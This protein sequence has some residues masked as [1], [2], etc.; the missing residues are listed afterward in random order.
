[1]GRVV[2]I[3]PEGNP[4]EFSAEE[5]PQRIREGY[6][7]ESKQ[8]RAERVGKEARLST[9]SGVESFGQAFGRGMTAGGTDVLQRAA[10]GEAAAQ[11]L[12]EAQEAHPTLD[13]V[14]ELSGVVLPAV[15]S[16]GTSV[17]ARTPAAA[18]TRFG[19]NIARAGEGASFVTKVGRAAAGAATEGALFGAGTGASEVALS[20]KPVDL[21]RAISTISSNM[22]YG[23]LVGGAAGSLGKVA[24]IG[25]TKAKGAIDGAL[26]RHEASAVTDDLARMD[27]KQLD[28]VIK[29]EKEAIETARVAERK[30]VAED[31]QALR[32][33]IKDSKHFLTTEEVKL[34]AV[35]GKLTAAEIGKKAVKA[36]GLLRNL[37]D[38]PRG[39]AAKPEMAAKALRIQED[40]YTALLDR[41]DDFR[42]AFAADK[43]GA[44]MAALDSIPAALEKNRAIQAQLT[45]LGAARSTERLAAAESA[46]EALK[47]GG[48]AL[49]Q[50]ASV[51]QRMV[52]GSVF[53]MAAGA[54]A[55]IP[56]IGPIAAP[57]VGA[58][59]AKYVGEKVFGRLSKAATDQAARTAK[60]VASFIGPAQKA[61]KA[62]VPV[63]TR[64]L[65][66]VRFAPESPAPKPADAPKATGLAGL[67]HERAHEIRSQT[68][69]DETGK[70]RM[71]EAARMEVA[72]RLKAVGVLSPGIADQLEAL[73]A[74]RIEFLASKLPKRPD[75]AGIQIGPD[76]WR[77]SDMEM[78]KWA[79]YVA[80]V[81]DPAG[82]EERLA[83]GAVS[84]EDAEVMRE[85]YPERLAELTRQIVEQL[86]T[87][88]ATL[89]YQRKLALSIMT[90]VPVVAA[91]DP[92][93][94][95]TLQET[96]AE[97]AGPDGEG[98]KAKPNFG[99]VSKSAPEPTPAQQ[100]SA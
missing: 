27:A 20:D 2:L 32:Q 68:A 64:V 50:V 34:P 79:R 83:D 21:E 36:D 37:L 92:R 87:V 15:M 45:E 95:G 16:G 60:A 72:D 41:A 75:V 91:M 82:I 76:R 54:T 12:R 73:A 26:A 18:I 29:T 14:G 23:G 1:M 33:E 49:A 35:E 58:A 53:G 52:E 17:L 84:V 3:S 47:A 56:V 100:R 96:F 6:T 10:G 61:T 78:R 93:I 38:D 90:G 66:T 55:A 85:V 59:A 39:F 65:S 70:P 69:Y 44:R 5:A 81:E 40:A 67:F 71:T 74:R 48:G 13:T 86:P 19:A 22:L 11:Y 4:E 57:M 8:G 94:L 43:T 98:P 51:P 31:I 25:L 7:E 97:E 62:A 89:P 88:R 77:P 63:A 42:A 9:I 46:K 80:G 28:S 99:S 24:E 30:S